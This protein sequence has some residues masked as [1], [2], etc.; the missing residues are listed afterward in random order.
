MT[1]GIEIARVA[2]T[3]LNVPVVLEAAGIEKRISLSRAKRPTSH[4]KG[5]A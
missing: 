1:A 3:P 4:G 5:K 2:A